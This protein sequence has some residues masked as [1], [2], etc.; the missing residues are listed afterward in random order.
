MKL[1]TLGDVCKFQK[2][3]NFKASKQRSQGLPILKIK[4]IQNGK[5]ITE[6]LTFFNPSEFKENLSKY[7]IKSNDIVIAMSGNTTGKVGIND[8]NTIF[9]LNT[10]TGRID[11]DETKINRRW[12]Y[13]F[14]LSKREDFFNLAECATQPNLYFSQ[15]EKVELLLPSLS[16]QNS[17][18]IR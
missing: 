7:Q 15:I 16:E 2:G 18:D 13:H 4:N 17:K 8:T 10:A 9:F 12:L 5:I 14:L 6:G 1:V 3:F 11:P